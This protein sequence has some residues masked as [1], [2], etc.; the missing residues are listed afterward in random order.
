MGK[1]LIGLNLSHVV[2]Q[3]EWGRHKYQGWEE[4]KKKN[5][6]TR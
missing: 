4:R 5:K 6:W 1:T 2:H 3:G